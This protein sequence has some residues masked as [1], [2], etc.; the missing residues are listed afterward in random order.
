MKIIPKYQSGGMVVN[1][2]PYIP[3]QYTQTGGA[4]TASS[5]SSSKESSDGDDFIKKELFKNYDKFL[6]SDVEA[7]TARSNI[8]GSSLFDSNYDFGNS[9]GD[10]KS[11]YNYMTR[12][13]HEKAMFD[14]AK[15]NIRAIEAQNEIA[16]DPDGALFAVKDG[17]LQK[18]L[19]SDYEQG[20]KLLT[21]KEVASLRANKAAFNS[22]MITVLEGATSMKQI[23]AILDATLKDLGESSQEA[24]VIK[25][26]KEL[27]I[28]AA[29]LKSADDVT[30]IM[31][32]KTKNEG[33]SEQLKH[34]INSAI[35]QLS[36]QMLTLLQIKAKNLG[37]ENPAMLVVEYM[38]SRIKGTSSIT[39]S[40]VSG[41]SKSSKKS[42]GDVQ[43]TPLM[44]YQSGQGGIQS[45]V[46]LNP[47]TSA[48]IESKGMIW[49]Q[50]I[51]NDNK[52]IEQSS[53][54]NLLNK[55][56]GSFTDISNG[57]YVG[58]Q[59][60]DPINYK[61]ILYGGTQLARVPL[62]YTVDEFGAIKPNFDL[63]SEFLK[64]D[65]LSEKE[66]KDYTQN[67]ILSS[68]IKEDGSWDQS[69]IMPFLVVNVFGT[70]SSNWFG[71]GF[72][73][74]LD[75]KDSYITNVEQLGLKEDE[76]KTLLESAGI[77]VEDEIMAGTAY[78]PVLPNTALA[79]SASGQH[80]KMYEK[81]NIDDIRNLDRKSKTTGYNDASSS[82]L[83]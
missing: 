44:Q 31:T 4:S 81:E 69:K 63:I 53:L 65:Q 46:K 50:P 8:F 17:K 42:T 52:P 56:I 83:Q 39:M 11:L 32:E 59:R 77:Q 35:Q 54:Q 80:P 40:G 13:A 38:S 47:G 34:A 1:P 19:A 15:E 21:N 16:V 9:A 6:P 60:V 64:L 36:P 5:V 7:F 62:P 45:T 29:A 10:Y 12:M 67:S 41:G 33:N 2:V 26:L 71:N 3:S 75:P 49:G 61:N 73:G 25:T 72:T 20:M 58:G 82:K 24:E 28:S 48:A 18:I 66:R 14:E 43:I 78:I 37:I 30:D 57:I 22:D 74:A 79:M 27:N 23:R 55:G 68:Y 70:G 51:G 76:V